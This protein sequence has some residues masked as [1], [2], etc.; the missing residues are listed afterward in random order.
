M[1]IILKIHWEENYNKCNILNKSLE[2]KI[3]TYKNI[4][5]IMIKLFRTN[6]IINLLNDS[7]KKKWDF[8]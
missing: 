4:I 6:Y 1:N 2:E 8:K 5:R 7:I 3:N